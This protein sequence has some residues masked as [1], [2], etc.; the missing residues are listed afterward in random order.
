[1]NAFQKSVVAASVETS[2]R[3]FAERRPAYGRDLQKRIELIGSW[4]FPRITNLTRGRLTVFQPAFGRNERSVRRSAR[5]GSVYYRKWWPICGRLHLLFT[6]H[7]LSRSLTHTVWLNGSRWWHGWGV[8]WWLSSFEAIARDNCCLKLGRGTEKWNSQL[9][10]SSRLSNAAN[11]YNAYIL[12]HHQ[13]YR[14]P[15]NQPTNQGVASKFSVTIT[16]INLYGSG[17]IISHLLLQS[18][19]T[20]T[21]SDSRRYNLSLHK[22]CLSQLCK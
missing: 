6:V 14:N 4:L 20:Q 8:R 7:T 5:L 11:A 15:T 22:N 16:L 9:S 2:A 17:N 1:M 10:S 13:R 3:S 18:R 19:S 12:N 21:R